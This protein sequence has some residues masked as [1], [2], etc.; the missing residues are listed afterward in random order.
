MIF[1]TEVSEQNLDLTIT[2]KTDEI[3][4]FVALSTLVLHNATESTVED[5]YDL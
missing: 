4:F 2:T 3:M 1:K 5:I